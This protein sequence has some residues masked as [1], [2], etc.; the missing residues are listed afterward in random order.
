[1]LD[2]ALLLLR[3]TFGSLLAGHGAQKLFGWFSGPGRQGTAQWAESLGLRPGHVWGTLAGATE[4]G[5]GS[6]MAL[7]LLN[8]VGPVA[9]V[10]AMSMATAR[11]HWGKPIWAQQGGA[12]LPMAYATAAAVLMLTGSGTFSLDR[13]LGI[14]LPRWTAVP[15]LALAAATIYAASRD[16]LRALLPTRRTPP[17][18]AESTPP[19]PSAIAGTL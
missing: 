15:G 14:R 10:S 7:G 17:A 5:G 18:T 1:M 6:L 3:A 16:D 12:E 4:F 9:A 8:P 13:A 2:L 11:V 19:R